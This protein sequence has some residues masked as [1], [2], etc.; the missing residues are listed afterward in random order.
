M[1][2]VLI[3]RL[4]HSNLLTITCIC[5]VLIAVS[6][7]TSNAREVV[8]L[9][10]KWEYA[11]C[12]ER[13]K[14]APQKGWQEV[15][16][17][18]FL[19][20]SR[21]LRAAWYRKTFTCPASLAGQ[22]LRL[23]FEGVKHS[24][25]VY[26]N[27]RHL[28]SNIDGYSPFEFDVTTILRPGA[29]NTIELR[30][31]GWA[32]LSKIFLDFHNLKPGDNV[33]YYPKNSITAPVGSRIYNFGI[34]Q[35]VTLIATEP[36]YVDDVW[37]RTSV[38]KG[39]IEADVT[40]VNAGAEDVQV[41]AAARVE[42]KGEAVLALP[43]RTVR[44]PAG[45][46]ATVTLA[47]EWK[48]P[49]LWWPHSPH[50]Y[51]LRTTVSLD[52]RQTDEVSTRFGFR[53]FWCDGAV[54]RLN[55]VKIKP[56]AAACHPLGLTREKAEET[57]EWLK[58]GNCNIMRLHAQ[59]WA[60][61]WY[62][63]ADE[64]GILIV[65][66]SAVWCLAYQ[67]ALDNPRFWENFERHELAQ[68]RSHRN[69]PSVV[70]WSI[71]NE[72]LHVGGARVS[73]TE[74]NLA[75]LGRKVK[76]L[77][78]TR[79]I[80][81]EGDEDPMG[82]A[83]IINLHYPH[84]YPQKHLYPDTA[85][86]LE[87][88]QMV[89]G[90]P[91]RQWEWSRKK[92]LYIGEYLW[93][94]SPDPSA[95]TVFFG[96][97]AYKDYARY[98]ILGKAMAW[99]MQIK[100]YRYDEV[101]A[102]CP[103]TFFEGGPFPNP[104]FETQ[105]DAMR[106]VAAFLREYDK[107]FFGGDRIERTVTMYNDTLFP[108][109]FKLQWELKGPQGTLASGTRN[110]HIKPA[111]LA[112]FKISVP[113]P[114]VEKRTDATLTIRVLEAGKTRFED[115][116]KWSIFPRTQLHAPPGVNFAV[117]DPKGTLEPVL[118]RAGLKFAQVRSL[119]HIPLDIDVLLIAPQAFE[120]SPPK[121]VVGNTG[122]LL[123][124]VAQGRK[125]IVLEQQVYPQGQVP[126]TLSDYDCTIAFPR[127]PRHPALK[128]VRRDDLRFWRGD[129]IVAR[130]EINWPSEGLLRPIVDSGS[131]EGLTRVALANVPWG[132][133]LFVLSQLTL[134]EKLNAEPIAGIILQ[135]LLD[136]V[137][138]PVMARGLT[139]VL[140]SDK[141]I[142]RT[143]DALGI[144]TT[145]APDLADAALVI[146]S[147]DADLLKQHVDE[148]D[149]F[150]SRGGTL[151]LHALTPESLQAIEE[152]LPAGVGLQ[153]ARTAPLRLAG[154]DPVTY[155]MTNEALYW[156]GVHRGEGWTPTPLSFDVADFIFA[157]PLDTANA[158]TL[159]VAT[160]QPRNLKS[161]DVEEDGTVSMST[162][163]SVVGEIEFD[164]SGRWVFGI[165]AK[166][167]PCYGEYPIVRLSI[168]DQ[169]AGEIGLVSEDWRIYTLGADVSAG[170]H[171]VALSFIN[172]AWNPPDEDRNLVLGD[173]LYA[174]DNSEIQMVALTSPEALV[175]IKHG[176]GTIVI[177]QVNWHKEERNR[178]KAM[179]YLCTLLANLGA[180]SLARPGLEIPG[181]DMRP[182]PDMPNFSVRGSA[183]HLASNGYIETDAE[184][185]KTGRY[186]FRVLAA[187]TGAK[188]EYPAIE[189]SIDGRSLGERQM[190]GPGPEALAF[191]ADVSAGR[192][193]IRI[194]F[195]NDF[196]DPPE[197]RNLTVTKLK[198]AEQE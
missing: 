55:G 185:E 191:V 77:D 5:A 108:G 119:E 68:V 149:G 128:G 112:R 96:D 120:P 131:P 9:D 111:E 23:R 101:T 69:H 79:P 173:L 97:E 106:P 162:N 63:V 157:P 3:T 114:Q 118:R 99:D 37:V 92:P 41:Q 6:A 116:H 178:A 151:L 59:P 60:K 125:A 65:H 159:H 141:R 124:F 103:W 94:P 104:L 61:V 22:H 138:Q 189:L 32:S 161:Y 186:R 19:Q 134:V 20:W 147:G 168:D 160:M 13:A 39:T 58:K 56:R 182:A 109:N 89:R 184:F 38:R 31:G 144:A 34:W 170:R 91:Y 158:G 146:A 7:S 197:D 188:G 29:E 126:A 76:A 25:E 150:V 52:G 14:V 4:L 121:R 81:Y 174:P 145:D 17:P 169:S 105:R 135:N 50:L 176:E 196:Y 73:S 82:A 36:V 187:G 181:A 83:D 48:S 154:Q 24:S 12:R 86:W 84:E 44:V 122:G 177:D 70:I 127:Q 49:K 164:R 71:E 148:L 42:D 88:K 123:K 51:F 78:P 183:A 45:G 62:D 95:H 140:S 67:Y 15:E 110:S 171:E 40:V 193:T 175:R 142:A 139:K 152:L 194:A 27:G 113:L 93:V 53:E 64:V 2:N 172:D 137:A 30:V 166:G 16:V 102:G 26:V 33:R 155:G 18:S 130:R 133:G 100:G 136:S 80:M 153:A 165:R 8:S 143:L 74:R 72:L 198:I 132:K 47:R 10:G 46:K 192:H 156:L 115:E 195:T 57:Y 21:T 75:D 163:G 190:A 129:H 90:W 117:F 98:R 43:A 85:Y 35:P 180:Q 107:T 179:R 28:G 66:E 11:P 87:K 54:F 1:Q 167:T